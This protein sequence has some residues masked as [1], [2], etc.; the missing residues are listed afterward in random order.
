MPHTE[1]LPSLALVICA[2]NEEKIIRQKMENCL[3]L[4][5]P[6]EKL[7]IVVISDGS[8]DATAAIVR[9]YQDKGIELIDQPRRRGKI[10][11]LNAVLP[12]R[13]E[14]IL[15]LSD[16]NVLYAPDALLHL[17]ERFQDPTVGCVSGRVILTGSAPEL[18][19][20]TSSYYSVEW[21]LQEQASSIYAMAGADGAMYALRRQL[22]RRC[23]DDTIVEDFIIPMSVIRQGRRTVFEPR[24]IGW[25]QGPASLGEEFR[26]KVRIAAGCMQGLLRGNAWPTG[27]PLRFW[28]IFLSHKLLRWL[29]PVVGLTILLLSSLSAQQW[30]SR[31]VVGGFLLMSSLALLRVATKRTHPLFSAPF[32]FLFGQVALGWGM[33]KGLAGQQTVLWAKED[34]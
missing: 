2:L 14:D 27:A 6:Q 31:A 30:I 11:N 28:F 10:A 13:T 4:R 9:E 17:A 29:S 32:Y 34:R 8:T 12:A 3:A 26:R 23:P 24:A 7:R 15:A 5:Y 25:E 1:S 22:F 21:L 33:L 16:A 19:Q 18:D 20:P